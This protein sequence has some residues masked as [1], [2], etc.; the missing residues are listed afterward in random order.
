MK[1]KQFWHL[2]SF[3]GVFVLVIQIFTSC[4]KNTETGTKPKFVYN[5]EK[6]DKTWYLPKELNEIS[7]LVCMNA[8][9]FV[10]INDEHGELFYFSM[11]QNKILDKLEFAGKGDF[12]AISYCNGY[13]YVANS[14][15]KIYKVAEDEGLVE[16]M[17]TSLNNV[18]N[19][20]GIVFYPAKNAL[21]IAPKGLD[22]FMG[23]SQT[24]I[25]H[26]VYVY[27]ESAGKTE[28][29]FTWDMEELIKLAG[30]KR[31]GKFTASDMA[32]HPY[33]SLIFIVSSAAQSIA[34]FDFNGK[35]AGYYALPKKTN[36]QPE[37]ICFDSL[38]NVYISNEGRRG[39]ASVSKYVPIRMEK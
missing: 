11:G 20:E 33:D 10:C 28:V 17:K 31:A 29:F 27:S 15:G 4:S 18:H 14:Q 5:F 35:L 24:E 23:Q 21:L 7:G 32:I 8:D 30:V 25:S 34:I 19:V 12:E 39:V 16:I 9:T 36:M 26:C 1:S 3:I 37:G 2:F 13:F 6:A 22:E 38:G